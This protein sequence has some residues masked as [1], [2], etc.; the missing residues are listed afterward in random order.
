MIIGFIIVVL[1][2]LAIIGLIFA[3]IPYILG[4]I[5][6][7]LLFVAIYYVGKYLIGKAIYLYANHPIA[8]VLIALII[9]FAVFM[10]R[11]IEYKREEHQAYWRAK[12]ELTQVITLH[13]VSTRTAAELA[14]IEARAKNR[15]FSK[16]DERSIAYSR[17]IREYRE[18]IM[19]VPSCE[20]I[21]FND[22]PPEIRAT[23]NN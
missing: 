12:R 4:G 17:L 20:P 15:G 2:A 11:Y 7:I 18:N 5:I 6:V 19:I 23:L 16:A 10:K 21:D 1:I 14:L 22:I 3:A 8:L 9:L 13:P